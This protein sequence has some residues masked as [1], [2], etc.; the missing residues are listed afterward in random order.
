VTTASAGI[1]PRARG[2]S[3]S[4]RVFISLNTLSVLDNLKS[5]SISPENFTGEK[6]RGRRATTVTGEDCARDLGSSWNLSSSVKIKGRQIFELAA[7]DG[8]GMIEQIWMT[9]TGNWPFN[10]LRFY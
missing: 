6:S 4:R 3:I 8:P 9:P 1:Q 10:I 7:I 5:K 2:T